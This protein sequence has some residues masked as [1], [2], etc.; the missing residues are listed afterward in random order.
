MTDII[1][2]DRSAFSDLLHA[3]ALLTNLLQ[4]NVPTAPTEQENK[5]LGYI[6]KLVLTATESYNKH[7][8]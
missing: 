1:K 8:Q 2:I 3:M 6:N 7:N 5:R 4:T